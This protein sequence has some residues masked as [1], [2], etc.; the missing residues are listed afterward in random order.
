MAGHN[1]SLL[2]RCTVRVIFNFQRTASQRGSPARFGTSSLGHGELKSLVL[3]KDFDRWEGKNL[4]EC[5]LEASSNPVLLPVSGLAGLFAC[6]Y[7]SNLSACH[8]PS[9]VNPP[10]IHILVLSFYSLHF[11]ALQGTLI[12]SKHLAAR[13]CEHVKPKHVI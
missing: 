5:H 12:S 8:F 10:F 11:L 4:V 6:I 13:N 3:G 2:P 1:E 7:L 9:E